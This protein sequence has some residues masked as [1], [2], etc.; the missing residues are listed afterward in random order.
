[1]NTHWIKRLRVAR[2]ITGGI[3]ATLLALAGCASTPDVRSDFDRS[4]DFSQYKTFAFAN[5]LGTDRSGYQTLVSQHLKAAARRELEARGMRLDESAP[6]VLVNFNAALSEKLRV[7]PMP[8]PT[9]GLGFGRGYYGYRMGMYGTFP[10]YEERVSQYTEG[11]LNIDIVDARRK[12]LVWEGVVKGTVTQK[13]MDNL[14]P[15]IDAAVTAAFAR[16]PVPGP[17]AKPASK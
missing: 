3:A 5:P 6:Q 12:Q 13:T 2:L 16:Y 1:M 8:A 14:Q 10:L 9:M 17:A 4:V 7:S 11:T 15:A